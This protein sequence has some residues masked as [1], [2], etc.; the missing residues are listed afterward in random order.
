MGDGVIYPSVFF[1]EGQG[2]RIPIVPPRRK[3]HTRQCSPGQLVLAVL[4][5][6]ALVGV[7]VEGYY[8]L[9][10]QGVLG[11]VP[12]HAAAEALAEKVIQERM[13][14]AE[15]PAA[16]LIGSENTT[17]GGKAL[18]WE[19]TK[20]WAFV[21]GL[22]YEEGALV[23]HQPGHYYVYSVVQLRAVPEACAVTSATH[24][25]YKTT[26]RYPRPLP[27]LQRLLAPHCGSG[28]HSLWAHGSALGGL[29]HLTPH[30]RLY[31]DV[32]PRH[33]LQVRDG[34]RSVFGAFML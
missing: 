22:G 32:K 19:S 9:R 25:V 33:L 5:S 27:L 28:N 34:T 3:P 10:L 18:L 17:K 29:V 23:C 30:D 24:R 8:L 26:P 6:L 20:D 11:Q 15:K 7:A 21:R 4:V 14:Q 31:V 16:H 2:D 12:A 13:L 1:V